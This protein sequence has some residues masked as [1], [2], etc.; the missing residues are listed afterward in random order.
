LT[1]LTSEFLS[2][3]YFCDVKYEGITYPTSEHAFQAAKTLDVSERKRIAGLGNPGLA[4]RAGRKLK[5]IRS[6]WD[7]IRIGVME[8]ILR[9]KF[10]NPEL[11]A[12]LLSTGEEK[13]VEGNDWGDRFWGVCDG[14]GE[15]WLGQLLMKIREESKAR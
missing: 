2:N 7:S 3:F 8:D 5:S 11:R 14:Q 10:S 4:K 12:K 13:L 9:I 15:N 6:N 1:D